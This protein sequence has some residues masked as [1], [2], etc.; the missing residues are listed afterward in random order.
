MNHF[1]V[2]PTDISKA[3]A[4]DALALG[5]EAGDTLL[6]HSSLKSLGIP[7]IT[8]QDVVLGLFLALGP[9]GTLMFPSLSYLNCNASNPI[10]DVRNTPS[11]IGAI[12]EWFRQQP[13]ILRSLC[14]TH[15]CSAL[16]PNAAMLLNGH[17]LD[18][19]PCGPNS[20]FARLREVH[21]KVLFLGCGT[22]CNTSMHAAEE[23]ILPP[24]LFGQMIP[25]TLIDSSG[26]VFHT[27]CRA[28]DFTG[29]IQRYDRVPDQM[30]SGVR[31]GNICAADC[32][33]LEAIPMWETAL[34]MLRADPY[35][36]VDHM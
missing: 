32:T 27:R 26:H 8:P 20:P 4:K 19:T 25:Y 17:H 1:S 6:V 10:F 18:E 2:K 3:I 31:R 14:P 34:T 5:V 16:G 33:L 13:G 9:E 23:V 11:C 30:L 29:V 12:P 28:H 22:R 35:S 24:Y 15:S 7:E 36:L 21:G